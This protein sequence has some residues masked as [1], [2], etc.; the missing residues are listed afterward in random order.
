MLCLS[1]NYE[2][3]KILSATLR[4]VKP[5]CSTNLF[6]IY[7]DV[8]VYKNSKYTQGQ[9]WYDVCNFVCQCEDADNGVYR[10]TER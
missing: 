9:K 10:C 6:I 1:A 5:Q 8:C 4:F 3:K 7:T 2:E